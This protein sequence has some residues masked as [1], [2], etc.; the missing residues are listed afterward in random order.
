MATYTKTYSRAFHPEE[1]LL[2]T[3]E[4][5]Y[6]NVCIYD[7]DRL[8]HQWET[9]NRFL[10]GV[11]F[12][13]QHLGKISLK[14]TE[15]R[16]LQLEL[17]VRNKKY[18]PN[19]NGKQTVDLTGITSVFYILAAFTGLA[20][21]AA[22]FGALN[23][24]FGPGFVTALIILAFITALYT[25]SAILVSRKHHWAFFIGT[26]YLLLSTLF[27]AWVVSKTTNNFLGMMLVFF[28]SL[29][30]IYLFISIRKVLFAM[31]NQTKDVAPEDLLDEKM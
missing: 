14:F 29:L 9:S 30:L 11:H 13:D 31:R 6:K 8:V 18:K 17:R 26:A 12:E 7:H 20:M 2:L 23:I 19:Q 28:K 10:K 25:A 16:P 3:W 4:P 24:G 22:F 27:N 15:T 21:V 1:T 5:G